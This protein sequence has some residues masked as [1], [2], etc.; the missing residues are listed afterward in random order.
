MPFELRRNSVPTPPVQYS[1]SWMQT[2]PLLSDL[3]DWS[4]AAKLKASLTVPQINEITTL[5]SKTFDI[6]TH[7]DEAFIGGRDLFEREIVGI[8]GLKKEWKIKIV[9]QIKLFLDIIGKHENLS[10]LSKMESAYENQLV[11]LNEAI[12]VIKSFKSDVSK[13]GLTIIWDD[14]EDEVKQIFSG[15]EEYFVK[16]KGEKS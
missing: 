6:Y 5:F 12:C 8:E 2:P 13:K 4:H 14:V 9:R 7:L 1:E 3:K 16:M 11:S 10:L 15:Y